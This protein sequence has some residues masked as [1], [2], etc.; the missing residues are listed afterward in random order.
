LLQDSNPAFILLR[1]LLERQ[2]DLYRGSISS[3]SIDF[4]RKWPANYEL[5]AWF[6]RLLQGGHQR[7]HNHPD[8]WLSG[9]IYL[10]VPEGLE[11]DEGCIEFML[12]DSSYPEMPGKSIRKQF[13][14]KNGRLVLFPSSL[15]H[16]TIPFSADTERLCIAFDLS[17]VSVDI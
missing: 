14:P 12:D 2:I 7:S 6:V 5:K 13:A 17:P 3:E 4:S 9:V 11:G 1:E 15:Y 10:S 16:R 8:G